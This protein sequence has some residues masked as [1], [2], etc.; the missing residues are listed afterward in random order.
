MTRKN[1]FA[2]F[3]GAALAFATVAGCDNSVSGAPQPKTAPSTSSSSAA[4]AGNPFASLDQCKILDEILA[5]Q[6]YSP[7]TPSV[8]DSQRSC[9]AQF[10]ST[11]Q[12]KFF[13]I[14][15]GIALQNGQKYTDNIRDP[16]TSR[17]GKLGD[18]PFIEQPE[19][20]GI[21]GGCQVGMSVGPN[22]RALV[23]A[24]SGTDTAGACKKAEQVAVAVDPKLPKN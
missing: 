8:A 2:V 14:T 12:D 3:A 15:V 19:P 17:S 24:A 6:G 9:Q 13:S 18:R 11:A 23:I 16:K 4:N 1:K 5:G 20:L 7:A 22:A 10:T 21:A